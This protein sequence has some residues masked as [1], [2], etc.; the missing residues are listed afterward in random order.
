MVQK[1]KTKDV[2]WRSTLI[3]PWSLEYL[4]ILMKVIR[5]IHVIF[6]Y[7]FRKFQYT[8]LTFWGHKVKGCAFVK[9][10]APTNQ[11]PQKHLRKEKFN[12]YT[13]CF[14]RVLYPLARQNFKTHIGEIFH[15]HHQENISQ[16][17]IW[18]SHQHLHCFSSALH[19]R[20][21]ESTTRI[22]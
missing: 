15:W 1:T 3:N 6:G 12:T 4:T 22:N 19:Q 14:M 10:S 11:K 13:L 21:N 20:N 8:F 18:N 5:L 17:P 16:Q 9:V 7:T 2:V